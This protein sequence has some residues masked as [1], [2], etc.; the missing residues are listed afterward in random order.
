[1]ST[2][3]PREKTFGKGCRVLILGATSGIARALI[4]EFARRG[5]NL[6]LAG[7]D[8]DEMNRIA[9]DARVRFD[10]KTEVLAFAALDYQRHQHFWDLCNLGGSVDGVVLCYGLMFPQEESERDWDKCAA[11]LE[12]NYNSCV[13]I[14]NIIANDFEE[15][16]RGFIG[17]LSS[18]AGDRGRPSNYLY[19]S[20]K[21]GLSAYC[22]GLRGRL[23][24]CGVSVTTIKPGPVDT[25]MTWG[26][27]KQPLLAPP[28]KVASDIYR[29]I[30][31][32]AD[33]VYTPAP[34]RV[35]MGILRLVPAFIWKRLDF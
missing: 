29:G 32:K 30:R 27:K 22:E 15:R 7:R 4:H 26:L 21:S 18:V 28:E 33:V 12:T 24:K 6:V 9:G 10:C 16:Q 34:W 3:S 19:G 1:M 23:F 11:M 31:R 14:L 13:S 35:L 5:F 2:L 20:A 17:V 25:A 8:T